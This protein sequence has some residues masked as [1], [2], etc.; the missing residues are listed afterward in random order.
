MGY[1]TKMTYI[2]NFP[3]YALASIWMFVAAA[4]G[5]KLK[6]RGPILV[7]QACC[8]ILGVS[9]MAF[10]H[11]PAARYVGVFLGVGAINA[12]IPTIYSYQHNNIS[13]SPC[14]YPP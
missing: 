1:S 13:T 11:Q 4:V 8:I 10:I 9:M 14:A 7:F 12:N 2:L 3:P 6:V 5:D